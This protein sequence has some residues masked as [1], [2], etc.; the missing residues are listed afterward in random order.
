MA[1][2]RVKWSRS[3]T[4]RLWSPNKAFIRKNTERC[5]NRSI[6]KSRV[7]RA[8][9]TTRQISACLQSTH[10]RTPSRSFRRPSW[11]SNHSWQRNHTASAI[12]YSR[13][14]T[15]LPMSDLLAEV[16]IVAQV[17]RRKSWWSAQ[18]Q[19]R[20]PPKT[21]EVSMWPQTQCSLFSRLKRCPRTA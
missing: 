6:F 18:S 21:T 1:R 8:R 3:A 2:A 20:Q 5:S 15:T 14:T 17:A 19:T 10:P 9:T 12:K 4:S 11:R 13:A 16:A 7:T